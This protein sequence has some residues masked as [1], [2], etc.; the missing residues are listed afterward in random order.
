M[1]T[2]DETRTVV[3]LRLMILPGWLKRAYRIA[4]RF[5]LR[6][7]LALNSRPLPQIS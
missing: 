2:F 4:E 5:T 1:K 6:R 3:G 7:N